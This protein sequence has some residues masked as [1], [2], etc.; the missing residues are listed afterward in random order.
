[1][2]GGQSRCGQ[3]GGLRL[4]LINFVIFFRFLYPNVALRLRYYLYFN[5]G[6]RFLNL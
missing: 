2:T 6:K 4:D 1:V 5:C 3:T